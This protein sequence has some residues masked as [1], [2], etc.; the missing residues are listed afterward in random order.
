MVNRTDCTHPVQH[1]T[2][3]NPD[4]KSKIRSIPDFPKKGIMFRDITTLLKDPAAFAG[5]IDLLAEHYEGQS[6]Q[7]VVSVEAR[8]F[9]LGAPL[10]CRLHAGFVPVRK[11]GKLPSATIKE[12]YA[13]EY[14]T[15]TLEIHQDAIAP[16]ERVLILDDLLATGGTVGATCRLVERLGGVVVGLG[17]LIELSFLQGRKNFAGYDVYSLI[18]YA[19]EE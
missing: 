18:T 3:M 14:G 12:S 13:L 11:P 9:I 19:G 5:A 10:A 1:R 17:F 4:L 6:I 15:D 7:K 8:G 16:G 2:H